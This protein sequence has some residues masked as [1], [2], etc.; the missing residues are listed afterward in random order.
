[1]I[2][3]TPAELRELKKVQDE[4]IELFH[5]IKENKRRMYKIVGGIKQR[6]GKDEGACRKNYQ[7]D[8]G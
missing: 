6:E 8:N 5:R 4:N 2:G 7:R 3:A 1:M